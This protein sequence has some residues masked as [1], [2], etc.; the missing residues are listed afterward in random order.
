MQYVTV[1]VNRTSCLCSDRF[2]ELRQ[3]R[4]TYTGVLCVLFWMKLLWAITVQCLRKYPNITIRKSLT[5]IFVSCLR[6]NFSFLTA[7]AKLVLVRLSQWKGNG[8]PTRSTLG[9]RYVF[10]H[11]VSLAAVLCNTKVDIAES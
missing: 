5:L 7:M 2:L 9:K 8:P 10:T 6:L 4:L 3:S 1:L 11:E